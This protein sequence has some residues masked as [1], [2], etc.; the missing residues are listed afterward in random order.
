MLM[1][2]QGPICTAGIDRTFCVMMRYN[3]SQNEELVTLD[4]I[5][6]DLLVEWHGADDFE[7]L[8]P[9]PVVSVAFET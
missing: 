9:E 4:N 8:L 1:A 7:V 2:S 5:T 6:Q 3:V